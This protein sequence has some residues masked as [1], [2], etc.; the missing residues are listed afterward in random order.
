MLISIFEEVVT[1][2]FIDIRLAKHESEI[3]I[4]ALGLIDERKTDRDMD[5]VIEELKTKIRAALREIK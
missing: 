2:E 5:F 4:K 1:K 3:L